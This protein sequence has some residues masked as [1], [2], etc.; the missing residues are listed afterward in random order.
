[1]LLALLALFAVG[2]YAYDASRAGRIADGVTV[3]GVEIGGLELREARARL[4]RELAE[5]LDR[6]LVVRY[7]GERF[8]LSAK[9]SKVE[10]DAGRTAQRA[11]NES[12]RGNIFARLYRSVAGG[13]TSRDVTPAMSYSKRA[14][15]SFVRRVKGDVN[16]APRDAQLSFSGDDFKKVSERDGIELRSRTLQRRLRREVVD[17]GADGVVRARTRTLKPK[18]R[19]RELRSEYPNLIVINRSAHELRYY[20]NLK[21]VKTY[22]IAVGQAGLETPAGLYHIQNKAVDPAWHVPNSDWAG[23]LAG[24]VIPSGAPDNPLKARWMGIYDGAGIHGTSDVGSLGTNA[25]HG[26]I[27]M[28]I[29]QVKELFRKVKVQTPVYIA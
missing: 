5:P 6:P 17:P 26:C 15:A 2:G 10:V 4:A 7:S 18:V 22:T 1:M 11:L 25:S 20:R 24:R 19:K 3:S 13:A 28:A 21:R 23:D 8:E 12:R 16:R 9:Q 27:R 29:P 14:V